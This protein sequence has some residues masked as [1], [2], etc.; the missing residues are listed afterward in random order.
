M[1]NT[2]PNGQKNPGL[3]PGQ[4]EGIHSTHLLLLAAISQ[5]GGSALLCPKDRA[6]HQRICELV[7]NVWVTTG[8]LV[9]S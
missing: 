5:F 1:C 3:F 2:D 6:F 8:E 7:T 4:G 9:S